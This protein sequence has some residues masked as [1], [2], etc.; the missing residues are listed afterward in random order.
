VFLWRPRE[1]RVKKKKEKKKDSRKHSCGYILFAS[2]LCWNQTVVLEK[3]GK[4]I[5]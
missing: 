5:F 1:S 3:H 2:P 4:L